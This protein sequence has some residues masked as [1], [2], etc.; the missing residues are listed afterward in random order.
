MVMVSD[1][2]WMFVS[3]LFPSIT[4][5]DVHVTVVSDSSVFIE[6]LGVRVCFAAVNV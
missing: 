5:G 2:I 3:G 4:F 1:V 6:T